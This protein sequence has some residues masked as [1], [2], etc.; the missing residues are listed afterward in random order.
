MTE[1]RR[2]RGD[3]RYTWDDL[4]A[5]VGQ[6]F[7]TGDEHIADETISYNDVVRYCEPWEISNPIHWDEEAAKQ[8][9]YRGVVVPWSA[10]KQTFS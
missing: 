1:E 9:G 3:P 5:A 6:D 2:M 10:I 4:V 7:A 8:M